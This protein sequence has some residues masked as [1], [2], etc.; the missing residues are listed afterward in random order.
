MPKFPNVVGQ[1]INVSVQSRQSTA[2]IFVGKT[3][4]CTIVL[5]LLHSSNFLYLFYLF[6][7][8]AQWAINMYSWGMYNRNLWIYQNFAY[9]WSMKMTL[10]IYFQLYVQMT[11]LLSIIVIY[12]QKKYHIS[13]CITYTSQK[14]A[15]KITFFHMIK[16][17]KAGVFMGP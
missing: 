8:I 12:L 17:H 4:T 7:I 13:W 3:F 1:S 2:Y 6:Y 16:V 9:I 14:H 15:P 5:H 11:S 10:D